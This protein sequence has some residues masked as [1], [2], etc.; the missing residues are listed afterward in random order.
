M[1]DND[2]LSFAGSFADSLKMMRTFWGAAGVSMPPDISATMPG[3]PSMLVPTLDVGE[4]DK[5]IADLRAVEQWLAVNANMLRAS[6]QTLEVQRNTIATLQTL[7]NTML[8]SAGGG[9]PK[10]RAPAPAAPAAPAP[11]APNKPPRRARQS[12]SAAAPTPAPADAPLD[13]SA[14]WSALQDQFTRIAAAAT[15]PNE[16]AGPGAKPLRRQGARKRPAAA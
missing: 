12:K 3:L 4:L 9:E 2:R 5:R 10:V 15:A 14:W 6:I 16:E 7:G 13:P 11:A 1:T 8:T